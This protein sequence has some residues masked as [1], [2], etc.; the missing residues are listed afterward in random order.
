MFSDRDTTASVVSKGASVV[1]GG[2]GG[3]LEGLS[4][5]SPVKSMPIRSSGRSSGNPE[6]RPFLASL[7]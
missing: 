4:L 7:S 2:G 6:L 1:D 3:G 5:G